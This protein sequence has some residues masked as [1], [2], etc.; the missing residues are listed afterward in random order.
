MSP[1]KVPG[2]YILL[3]RALLKSGI[4]ECPPLYVKLWIWL[5]LNASY[6]DHGNLKRGQ[7]F[8]TLETMQSAMA[9]KVGYRLQK[10]SIKE[11]RGATKFLT[12]V[13][14]MVITRVTHGMVI[15]IL[16]YDI[17]QSPENYEGH[18][19]GAHAGHNEGTILTRKEK[20]GY[21]ISSEILNLRKK[22]PD[23]NL[24]DGAFQAIASTRKSNRVAESILLTQLK[25]WERYP[26][27]QVEAGIRTYLQKD[28]AGEG[29]D[30]AYLLGIIRKN[31]RGPQK[32]SASSTPEWF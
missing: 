7:L 13:R 8:T 24:I 12:K 23:Q 21:N 32:S 27:A 1:Q 10:P 16:N 19:E 15:T 6:K 5:L 26:V 18:D 29:K 14:M 2:G 31:H 9:F 20:K 22:Y 3:A 25:K 17:Y 11:I 28:C 30:E 4:M